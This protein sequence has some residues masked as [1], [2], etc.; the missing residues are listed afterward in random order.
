MRIFKSI[1]K[2]FSDLVCKLDGHIREVRGDEVW[3]PRCG[4]YLGKRW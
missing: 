3:C 2:S 4:A 1:K